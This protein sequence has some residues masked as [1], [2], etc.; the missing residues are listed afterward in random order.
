M[1]A[2]SFSFFI[3]F[4]PSFFA[5]LFPSRF[6]RCLPRHD[7]YSPP[8]T[9]SS[10]PP[11]PSTTAVEVPESYG[12]MRSSK[13]KDKNGNDR[14]KQSK[15]KTKFT[16]GNIFPLSFFGLFISRLFVDKWLV[17]CS[18]WFFCSYCCVAVY[19]FIRVLN[20]LFLFRLFFYSPPVTFQLFF[21]LLPVFQQ[22]G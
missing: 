13:G 6:L 20:I 14:T 18:H 22:S 8:A 3:F 4:L 16:K 2:L 9:S 21:V 1:L 5:L 7:F 17:T 10:S 12:R 19:D 15:E 11:P